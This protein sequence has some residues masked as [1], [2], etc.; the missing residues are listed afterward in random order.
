MRTAISTGVKRAAAVLAAAAVLFGGAAIARH[1]GH[2]AEAEGAVLSTCDRFGYGPGN[3]HQID[4]DSPRY[5]EVALDVR[6][7]ADDTADAARVDQRWIRLAKSLE[8]VAVF[9]ERSA[10][11]QRA[12]LPADE[13]AARQAFRELGVVAA[14]C[15]TARAG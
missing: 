12:G 14:E 6:E 10:D 7:A 2:K 8:A 5:G 9:A 3:V 11:R 15:R 1:Y 4:F 13:D